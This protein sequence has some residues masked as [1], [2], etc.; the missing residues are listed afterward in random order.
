[1]PLDYSGYTDPNQV[2]ATWRSRARRLAALEELGLDV[3]VDGDLRAFCDFIH[4]TEM[5]G[6]NPVLDPDRHQFKPDETFWLR[7][8]TPD[9]RI[10]G[11]QG[12]RRVET[13][14][15]LHLLRTGALLGPPLPRFRYVPA[16][17]E[18]AL[19]RIGGVVAHLAGL[20][21]APDWRRKWTADGNRLVYAFVRFTHAYILDLWRPDW[22]T[23]VVRSEVTK[24][25]LIHD[26]YGYP[27]LGGEIEWQ[28]HNGPFLRTTLIFASAAELQAGS[29]Q[30]QR[31]AA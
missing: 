13:P 22:S 6:V 29:S 4:T 7:L 17:N 28:F 15:Y 27:H 14:D 11:T 26:L 24:P 30:P 23:S 19:P 16:A 8:T 1:M 3:T 2:I 20:W 10:V 21:L 25:R 5:K 12:V 31:Q 18:D 9:G